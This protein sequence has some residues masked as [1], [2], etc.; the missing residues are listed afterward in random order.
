[1]NK[2]NQDKLNVINLSQ[3][4]SKVSFENKKTKYELLKLKLNSEIDFSVAPKLE[5]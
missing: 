5:N 3:Y 1:M 4:I 2:Q